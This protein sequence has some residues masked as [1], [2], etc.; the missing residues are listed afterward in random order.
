MPREPKLPIEIF[1]WSA[2]LFALTL[3][4]AAFAAPY[5]QANTPACQA[6][7]SA[8]TNQTHYARA[9]YAN[10]GISCLD[11]T[12]GA[13]TQ[14]APTAPELRNLTREEERSTA[15]QSCVKRY[16]TMLKDGMLKIG[17]FLGYGDTGPNSQT[18][19][20]PSAAEFL[21]RSLSQ[22]CPGGS[23]L[24]ACGF[25]LQA[26]AKRGGTGYDYVLRKQISGMDGTKNSALA[27]IRIVSSPVTEYEPLNY[28]LD[29]GTSMNSQEFQSERTKELFLNSFAI[30]DIVIYSGH[31]RDGGGPDFFQPVL[32]KDGHVDY[33]YYHK[34]KDNIIEVANALQNATAKGV[35]AQMFASFS[36]NSKLFQPRLHAASPETALLLSNNLAYTSQDNMAMLAMLDSVLSQRCAGDIDRSLRDIGSIFKPHAEQPSNYTLHFF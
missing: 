8:W 14:H 29:L 2:S 21:A 4:L 6:V 15:E 33:D 35:G 20:S 22:R 36:C 13:E 24:Q 31:S 1:V 25:N 32:T 7:T 27:E 23:S 30:D 16:G 18:N 28:F 26:S 10:D 17:I 34:H 3:G 11:S 9:Q 19:F 12:L 5:P